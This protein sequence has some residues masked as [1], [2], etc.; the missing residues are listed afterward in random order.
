MTIN[1]TLNNIGNLQDTTT[2][3]SSL[4]ANNTAITQGFTSALNV[5]GDQM[6]GTLN[7][8][9]QQIT[10][11]PAPG[12]QQSPVRLIDLGTNTSGGPLTLPLVFHA[13]TVTSLPAAST[14]KYGITFVT[15]SVT[16]ARSTVVAG[17]G[18]TII[19][20]YSNGTSWFIV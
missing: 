1:V 11:L 15:D 18:T 10:N 3:Q 14:Y 5:T 2:A 20:V 4:N 19:S 6:L 8:N 7:M 16:S 17:G 13:S 9:S 12:T